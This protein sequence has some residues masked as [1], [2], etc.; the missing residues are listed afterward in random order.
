MSYFHGKKILVP[1]DFSEASLE[2]I[3]KAI[4]IAEDPSSVTVVHVMIPLDL[5]SP[6]VL[7]G[8]LTDEKRTDHVNKLAK[9]EFTK[10]QIEGVTFETLIGDPGIKIADY[11]KEKEIEL[12]VIPSHGYTGLTR[13][14]L[15]S[16]AERVLRH[17]PCP[18]LVLRQPKS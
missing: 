2:A 7:F 9:E 13:L 3:K 14:A 1:V 15:G 18:T 4:E 12:I 5:V 16:V 10:H 6:G 17:A 11:A 8:G